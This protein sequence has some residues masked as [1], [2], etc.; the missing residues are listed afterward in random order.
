MKMNDPLANHLHHEED[1]ELVDILIDSDLYF[2]MELEE[3]YK[4][5]RYL[6]HCYYHCHTR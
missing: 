3:R 6:E 5:I 1:K 4:L 2:E